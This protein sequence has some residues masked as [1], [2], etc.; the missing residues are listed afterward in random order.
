MYARVLTNNYTLVCMHTHAHTQYCCCIL[1]TIVVPNAPMN[2]MSESITSRMAT[3]RWQDGAL[4][5]P[6]NPPIIEYTIF[7]NDSSE[8]TAQSTTIILND[9]IPFT[10]YTVSVVATNRIGDSAMSQPLKFTTLEE[11]KIFAQLS[12]PIKEFL[13]ANMCGFVAL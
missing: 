2:V 4:L 5:N 12:S 11:G 3:I 9:L 6:V 7:L 13:H 10:S 8:G 1:H